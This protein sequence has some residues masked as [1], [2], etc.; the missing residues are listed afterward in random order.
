MLNAVMNYLI[1]FLLLKT[2]FSTKIKILTPSSRK[3]WDPYKVDETCPFY[4]SCFLGDKAFGDKLE[5][6][7]YCLNVA[8]MF[9]GALVVYPK[10]SIDGTTPDWEGLPHKDLDGYDIAYIWGEFMTRKSEI[11][12]ITKITGRRIIKYVS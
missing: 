8:K 1:Y 12:V 9:E 5:N 6:F 10:S 4:V 2:I 7:I 3:D 11:L